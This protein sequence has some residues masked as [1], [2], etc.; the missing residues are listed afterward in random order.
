VTRNAHGRRRAWR[1]LELGTIVALLLL[2]LATWFFF[3][4]VDDVFAGETDRRRPGLAAE[5]GS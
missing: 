4:N 5:D 3:E 2:S 1:G